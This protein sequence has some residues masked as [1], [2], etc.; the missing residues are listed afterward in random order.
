MR[1]SPLLPFAAPTALLATLMAA[2]A[3]TGCPEGAGAGAGDDVVDGGPGRGDTGGVVAVGCARDEECGASEICDLATGACGAG[4]DC[5]ANA[6][7]CDF[8][9]D[10]NAD[11]G[12]GTVPAYCSAA[13]VCRRQQGECG[14]CDE[15]AQCV[16]GATGLAS[17]CAPSAASTAAGFCTAGCGACPPGF[18]CEGGGCVP[19]GGGLDRCAA[20]LSC[21]ADGACP[22][23]QTCTALELC[24][25]LCGADADCPAGSIC[26]LAA[27]PRQQQCVAGCPL[28]D[29]AN[30][31]GTEVVCHADGRFAPPCPTEG[32]TTGCTSGTSCDVDGVCQRAG[33]QSDDECPLVRTFCDLERALCVD[34]CNSVDDCGSFEDCQG[35]ACQA[36]GCQGQNLSCDLGQFCCGTELFTDVSTCPVPDGACFNAPD[37]WCRPCADNSDCADIDAF[38]QPSLCFELT[39]TNAAGQQESLGK[40]CSVG[41]DDSADCPRGV[42]CVP[43]LPTE[44]EGVTARGC[45]DLLC[46]AIAAG[47]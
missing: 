7:L 39:R 1:L 36:L 24:L 22:Q 14:L 37:P 35:G 11:C 27:G 42:D 19:A 10:F 2:M 4:L 21:A 16:E 45:L 41:C 26:E 15:D 33:C 29:I 17:V 30:Q 43:D 31:N 18:A 38:G 8:C 28:G 6:G 25:E 13:G 40:Y 5:T 23:G 34:G 32:A 9:G 44:Q 12:F 3:L 47:R 20:A 46:P